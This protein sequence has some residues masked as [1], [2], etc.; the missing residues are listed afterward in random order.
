MQRQLTTGGSKPSRILELDGLRGMAILMVWLVHCFSFPPILPWVSL[1]WTG[2]DLFFVLSGFLI[3][4][5][6]LDH[7]DSDSYFKTFYL[8]RF[9]RI[10]PVYY[11]WTLAYVLLVTLGASFLRS[12]GQEIPGAFDWKMVSRYLFLQN[13]TLFAAFAPGQISFFWFSPT[14]SLAVEEQFYLVSPLLVR[15]LSK[16]ILTTFLAFVILAAP[17][18]RFFVR[19]HFGPWFAFQL[20]PCRADALAMG[21]LVAILWRSADFRELLA[22]HCT[23][24]YAIFAVLFAGVMFLWRWHSAPIDRVMQTVGYTWLAVFYVVILLLALSRPLGPIARLARVGFLRELGK[25]SYCIYIVH[26]T[27]FALCHRLLLHSLPTT[28]NIRTVAVTLLAG[29]VTY[30]LAKASWWLLEN[31]ML[32]LGHTFKY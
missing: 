15:I 29:G 12:H 30:A 7:R 24:I 16:R 25:V 13:F 18:V 9:F 5:I 28:T 17:F 22:K 3:G 14:W 23:A 11:A 10:I 26:F 1:G 21:V 31:P 32:R 2:V 6:L 8:Q 27:V 20:M 19:H 4:G